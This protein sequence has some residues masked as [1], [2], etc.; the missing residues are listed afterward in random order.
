MTGV[1]SRSPEHGVTAAR[2]AAVCCRP[3]AD[4]QAEFSQLRLD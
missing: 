4:A 1:R 2:R 3:Y